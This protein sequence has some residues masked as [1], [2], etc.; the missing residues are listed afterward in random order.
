MPTDEVESAKA[1]DLRYSIPNGQSIRRRRS[2]SGFVYLDANGKT[3]RDKPTLERIRSLVI[4]L[5]F[6]FRGKSGQRHEIAVED[7]RLVWP[8]AFC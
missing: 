7:L 8:S 2:G 6:R 4:P 5:K 3:I 1:A